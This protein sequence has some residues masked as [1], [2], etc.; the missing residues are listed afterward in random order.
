MPET[1][2]TCRCG[3]PVATTTVREHGKVAMVELPFCEACR[4][5]WLDDLTPKDVNVGGLS[6]WALEEL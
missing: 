5:K 4:R 1:A 2:L 6:Q 3:E